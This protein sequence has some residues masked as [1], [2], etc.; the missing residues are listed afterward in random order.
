MFSLKA[1]GLPLLLYAL[2]GL[3]AQP[4]LEIDDRER[5]RRWSVHLDNDLFA[6]TE[7]DHDYTAGVAFSLGGDDARSHPLSLAKALAWT[8]ARTGFERLASRAARS[9]YALDLGLLLFTP[10]DL[11]A[12]EPLFDDRPYASLAYVSASQLAHDSAT[13][14]VYQ[15]SL[16][17]GA[18][19]LPLAETLHRGIHEA[20][21]SAEP[22]GY[23]NAISAGGEPTFRYA[24]ARRR[25]LARG[26]YGDRPY[27]LQLGAGA[28]VGYVTEAAVEI[29]FRWGR[30][31]WPWWSSLPAAAEYAGQPPIG[32][33][34]AAP[35]AARRIEVLF[36]AG[37]KARARLYNAFLEGQFRDSAVT[38]ESSELNHVLLD[39]WLG[40]TTVIN[41]RLSVSYT[42]RRQT[43][44]LAAGRGARAFTWASIGVAQHF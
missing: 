25:L 30:T 31:R 17:L 7:R 28:S 12:R 32:V 37:V 4:A 16:T 44:E 8:D 21:G 26:S 1:L 38:F 11:S 33:S 18:L 24:V 5:G 20:F 34:D 6:F 13:E 43:Q 27:S 10:Q 41:G 9:G 15:S 39:A 36:D 19:G 42:V 22:R 35:P 14:T 3:A 29:G 40:V 23:A 2:G